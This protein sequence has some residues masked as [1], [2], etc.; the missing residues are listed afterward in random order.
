PGIQQLLGDLDELAHPVLGYQL[1]E[2]PSRATTLASRPLAPN[3]IKRLSPVS[4]LVLTLGCKFNC[5][6]CPIPAYNQRQHRVKSGERVADEMWQL[7][8]QYGLR[9]FFGVDD[10]FFN[11]KKETL[12]IVNALAEAEF[13]GV[14]LRKKARWYTE[15]TVH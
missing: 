12:Q 14:P 4:S 8:K 10:N 5:S 6:Y 1:I 3:Q 15:V 9:Y 7:N 13:D 2:A 11:H